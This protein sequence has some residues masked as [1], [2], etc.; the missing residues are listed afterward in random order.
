M[1][2]QVHLVLQAV[3]ADRVDDFERFLSDVVPPAVRATRPELEGRWRLLRSS[4]PTDGVVTFAMLFEGGS[5]EKDWELG[6]LLPPHYGEEEADRLLGEW[7]ETFAPL[8]RWAEA[9]VRTTEGD[10]A[11]WTMEPVESR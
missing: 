7:S 5:L 10:Q 3:K 2:D 8:Q 6:E 11:A 4:E 1:S 9:T